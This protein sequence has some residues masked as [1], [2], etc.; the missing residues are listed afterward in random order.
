MSNDLD[1]KIRISAEL[2]EIRKALSGLK[3]DLGT[4]GKAAKKSNDE[5]VS[6]MAGLSDAIDDIIVSLKREADLFGKTAQEAK[7]YELALRGA[8][9]AEIAEA[10]AIVATISGLKSKQAAEQQAASAEQ[11]RQASIKRVVTGLAEEVSALGK[12]SKE[13]TIYKLQQLGATDAE[14][15]HARSLLAQKEAFDQ[16]NKSAG[17]LNGTMRTVAASAAAF[18]SIQGA[19]S[20]TTAIA[21]VNSDY[22]N[23]A[24]RLRIATGEGELFLQTQNSLYE[25]AQNTSNE[26]GTVNEL[27][28][29]LARSTKNLSGFTNEA[30]IRLTDIVGKLVALGGSAGPSAQAALVQFGQALNTG[31]KGSGQE[32]Q[33]IIEQAPRLA[34][35]IEQGAGIAAGGLKKFAEDG[36]LSAEIVVN[37]ILKMG[38][39][40]DREFGSLNDT[41]DKA[42]TRLRNDVVKAVGE[43]DLQPLIASIDDLRKTVNDPSTQQ[44][45]QNLSVGIAKIA[46][47]GIEAAASIGD[48]GQKFGFLAAKIAG[49]VSPLDDLEQKIKDVD[50]AIKGSW[51]D[52]PLAFIFKNDAELKKIKEQLEAQRDAL[53]VA[54]GGLTSAQQKANEE[55]ALKAKNKALEDQADAELAAAQA[56]QVKAK[57]EE[58]AEKAE[59]K[60]TESIKGIIDNLAE[61]AATEGKSA[62]EAVA[63]QLSQLGASEAERKRA[64]DL[65]QQ[66]KAIK[67]KAEAE[68]E[69]AKEAKRRAEI[70]EEADKK[71]KESRK[72]LLEE[73]AKDTEQLQIDLLRV[74]GRGAEAR[75]REIEIKYRDMIERMKLAGDKAGLALAKSLIDKET[76]QVQF[77]A[78]QEKFNKLLDDLAAK[79]ESLANRVRIGDI[80]Q[81]QADTELDAARR[82][83]QQEGAGLIGQAT[84][85]S[86]GDPDLQNRVS[87]MTLKLEGQ[88]EAA[89]GL[90]AAY[91]DLTAQLKNLQDNLA[92]TLSNAGVDALT[93]LFTDLI[94]GSKSAKEAVADFARGFIQSIIQLI[95]KALA[96]QAVLLVL[97]AIPGGAAVASLLDLTAKT[98]AAQNHAGGIAGRGGAWRQVNPALFAMAPRYHAGGVAGLN[99]GEVPA[100]LQR[101]EEVLTQNDPRHIANGGGQSGGNVRIINAIDPNM[102]GDYFSSSQGEQTLVNVI[103]R[104]SGIVKQA[105]YGV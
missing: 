66:I 23:M 10:R 29:T 9:Q 39:E 20:L 70:A 91:A 101:G 82:G 33:S 67:D 93:G 31:F 2:G 4:V 80:T 24:S 77:D 21:R 99:P 97:N 18:F 15:K 92:L 104:N 55:A 88:K 46:A 54:Q 81:S 53:L 35:A 87:Q 75:T 5:S 40:T 83:V 85:A 49:N 32:I 84:A 95:A 63:Y 74:E 89:T 44:G 22:Q 62:E 51:L 103:Q 37:A 98:G 65:A 3:T 60:R 38:E 7:L 27:Y 59:K 58:E 42:M 71:A 43:A 86:A 11:A 94:E 17:G 28:T 102:V 96:L 30:R 1:L 12:T 78:I 52:K 13:L 73:V 69:A 72:K 26:L 25:I 48:M 45:L 100:I 79:E 8:T 57:Q 41:V 90:R 76:A 47:V 34:T 36:K 16:V 61:Q 50:Q 68:K 56:A 19:V 64:A 6:G 105:V 14:I